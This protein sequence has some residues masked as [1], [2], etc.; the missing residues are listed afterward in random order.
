VAGILR[1]EQ[2]DGRCTGGVGLPK[3]HWKDVPNGYDL[4]FAGTA[5]GATARIELTR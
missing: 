4:R 2:E 1:A 5:A 3:V